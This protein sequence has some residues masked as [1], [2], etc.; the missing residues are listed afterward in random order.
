MAKEKKYP[1]TIV[2]W[3]ED[4]RLPLDLTF[5]ANESDKTLKNRFEQLI[6]DCKFFDCLVAY[7]Y[8]SGFYAIYK[9][10]QKTER[11]KILIRIGTPKETYDLIRSAEDKPQHSFQFSHL[12]TKQKIENTVENEMAALEDNQNVE[13]GVQKLIDEGKAEKYASSDFRPHFETDLKSDLEIFRKI[14]SIWQSIKM[15]QKLETLLGNLKK[16]HILKNK[17]IIIFTETKETSEYLT[18]NINN[19]NYVGKTALLFH[20]NSPEVLRD[21]VIE[22]FDAM[23]RNKRD[24]YRILVSTEVLSEGVNLHGSNIVINYDIPWNPTR[25]MQRV[26]RINRIDTSFDKIHT[27]NFFPTRQADSKIELT[28]IARSKIEAFLTLLG[29]D[30]SIL[31]EGEPISSHELFDKLLSKK[32]ITEDE[33]EKSELKYLRIIEDVRDKNPELFER[34]KRLPKKARSAKIFSQYLKD[35]ASADSLITFFRKGKLMKFFLSDNKSTIELDFLAYTKILETL[36]DE[37]RAKL[38]LENYYEFLD[39]NKAAFFNATLE[40]IIETRRR[41]GKSSYGELLKILKVTQKNTKQLTEDQDEYLKKIINRLEEGSLP[42]QT[43]K[44]TLNALNKLEKD[45]QN[46]LKVIGTLQREISP[47]FIKSHYAETSAITEGKREVVLSLYLEEQ[48]NG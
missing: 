25:L 34:I 24:D 4:E 44:K 11:I 21:G 8:V 30:T 5:I 31:T 3:S 27:F 9:P 45:I 1:K 33:E 47:A 38:P 46:P 17:R 12:E 22:N 14:K 20:G 37:K 32:T 48:S 7:F 29:G 39:K 41:G 2:N 18:E 15:D 23:A 43:V 28:N 26:G 6:K 13:E 36:P 10:L 16:H 42:K 35:I 40:E 19:N